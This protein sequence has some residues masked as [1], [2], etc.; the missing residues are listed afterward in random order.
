MEMQSNARRSKRRFTSPR[1]RLTSN[2]RLQYRAVTHRSRD[3]DRELR[4]PFVVDWRFV[5]LVFFRLMFV[6][7]V[8]SFRFADWLW[9]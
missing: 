5:R 6:A 8:N 3:P 2:L 1:A 7:F 4:L 9:T